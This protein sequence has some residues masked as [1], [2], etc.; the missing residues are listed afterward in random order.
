MVRLPPQ[1]LFSYPSISVGTFNT[2][3]QLFPKSPLRSLT[4]FPLDLPFLFEKR[5]LV[6]PPQPTPGLGLIYPSHYRQATQS[7]PLEERLISSAAPDTQCPINLPG[8]SHLLKGNL[9]TWH[10][11]QMQTRDHACQR[12]KEF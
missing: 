2:C 10:T 12:E 8:S 7:L 1:S 5:A 3:L 4:N 9:H 11:V 6:L